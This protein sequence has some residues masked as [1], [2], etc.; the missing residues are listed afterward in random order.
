[1]YN[2]DANVKKFGHLCQGFLLEKFYTMFKIGEK[3]IQLIETKGFTKRK[4]YSELDVSRQTLDNWI[5][6][7]HPVPY[8]YLTKMSKI[9]GTDLTQLTQE[10]VSNTDSAIPFYDTVAVGGLSIM[11]EQEPMYEGNYQLI[12]PGTWFKKATGALRIYGHSMFPKYPAGCIVAFKSAD[13]DVIIWGEDYVIEL[14]D[15][16]IIKRIEKGELGYVKAV[17]YNKSEEYVYSPIDIPLGK[18]KRLY[19]VLGKVELEA[20]I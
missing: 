16:R 12:E 4:I 18:I 6:N 14:E 7:V 2:R 10:D 5:K 13:L 20:S 11:A 19:M 3:I 15:R 8:E 17:S 1:M 9:L